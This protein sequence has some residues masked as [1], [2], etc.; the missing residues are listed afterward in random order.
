MYMSKLKNMIVVPNAL[1]VIILAIVNTFAETELQEFIIED[2]GITNIIMPNYPDNCFVVVETWVPGIRFESNI[3]IIENR[4]EENRYILVLRPNI[5][6]NIVVSA[7]G[8]K[9]E[10][11]MPP[12]LAEKTG[13]HY[14]VSQKVEQRGSVIIRTIP[15]SSSVQLEGFKGVEGMTPFES[16]N[17]LS[18][19]HMFRISKPYY[20]DFPLSI[21]VPPGKT[22]DTTVSLKPDTFN[23][24]VNSIPGEAQ[25]FIDN[26][27]VGT[28]PFKVNSEPAGL[29]PGKHSYRMTLNGYKTADGSFSIS[30][31]RVAVIEE[32]LSYL[33]GLTI[34]TIPDKATVLID[35]IENG[36]TPLEH[37]N[38]PLG[39]HI[40]KIRKEGF[41]TIVDTISVSGTSQTLRYKMISGTLIKWRKQ[42]V[43]NQLVHDAAEIRGLLSTA[44]T[45][46]YFW[47]NEIFKSSLITKIP[48]LFIMTSHK[49]YK[50]SFLGGVSLFG[51]L[52]LH[53]EFFILDMVGFHL[54]MFAQNNTHTSRLYFQGYAGLRMGET[55]FRRRI[56]LDGSSYDTKS[57]SNI[58][59]PADALVRY[60]YT[61]TPY[62]S[63]VIES[64]ALWLCSKY[65]WESVY[66]IQTETPDY[67][68][69]SEAD[70]LGLP[71]GKFSKIF[72]YVSAGIRF[73]F[74]I[75]NYLVKH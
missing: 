9:N 63:F 66:R 69:D 17:M 74:G 40:M 33:E 32:K 34:I 51:D 8:F 26:K 57:T 1:F 56:T 20:R 2:N 30:P 11:I 64:G 75:I 22:I 71:N 23:L 37:V 21:M 13:I 43:A 15:D 58:W 48:L 36:F 60:E 41:E 12:I 50:T 29:K 31:D 10:I 53:D 16:K 35:S 45:F 25:V 5:R 67:F 4:K 27:S 7:P 59:A 61:P 44:P 70:S 47:G 49:P 73:H 28:T 72:P 55:N 54:G 65:S 14:T 38:T 62:F 52:F 3:G 6:H 68:S 39:K 42:I 18:G 19:A 24:V 46:G